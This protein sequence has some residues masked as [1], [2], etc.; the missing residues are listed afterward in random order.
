MLERF[1]W[2]VLLP[3]KWGA[4]SSEKKMDPHMGVHYFGGAGVFGGYFIWE[5]VC[6]LQQCVHFSTQYILV[7][8]RATYKINKC[9]I[10]PFIY[11]VLHLTTVRESGPS[12]FLR[13]CSK[14][15]CS[16]L[17]NKVPAPTHTQKPKGFTCRAAYKGEKKLAGWS[18]RRVQIKKNNLRGVFLTPPL[19]MLDI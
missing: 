12:A 19:A 9:V 4:L 17:P 5:G 18:L 2:A 14:R 13:P 11:S 10:N 1:I 7:I 16:P 3:S 6:T 15:W 8:L